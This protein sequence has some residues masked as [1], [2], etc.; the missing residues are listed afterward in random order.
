M[1]WT[2]CTHGKLGKCVG[3]FRAGLDGKYL[4]EGRTV[5]GMIMFRLIVKK[6]DVDCI[7]V[8]YGRVWLLGFVNTVMGLGFVKRR[9]IS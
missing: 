5:N 9:E 3:N 8:A 4:L 2:C 1:G 6:G 7:H